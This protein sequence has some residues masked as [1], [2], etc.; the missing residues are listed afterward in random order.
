MLI[1]TECKKCGNSFIHT[2]NDYK[3]Y[4]PTCDPHSFS[5]RLN[6]YEKVGFV[7][8]LILISIYFI[9]R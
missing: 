4:C 1:H 2:M 9:F 8:L 6:I 7:I 3:Q 5:P